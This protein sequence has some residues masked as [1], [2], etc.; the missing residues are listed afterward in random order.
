LVWPIGDFEYRVLSP[1]VRLGAFIVRLRA[2]RVIEGYKKDP[3]L[4]MNELLNSLS[5]A[6]RFREL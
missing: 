2:H 1:D 5:G 6:Y 4:Y 3:E